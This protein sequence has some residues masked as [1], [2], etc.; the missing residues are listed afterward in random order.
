[1]YAASDAVNW[2]SRAAC[3]DCGW[4]QS[5]TAYVPW[6]AWPYNRLARKISP[7]FLWLQRN[8]DRMPA[9]LLDILRD[10]N[11]SGEFRPMWH[12]ILSACIRIRERAATV[13]LGFN[14]NDHAALV[15]S[16]GIRDDLK[17]LTRPWFAMADERYRIDKV[18]LDTVPPSPIPIRQ[19]IRQSIGAC[20]DEVLAIRGRIIYDTAEVL[21]EQL[22]TLRPDLRVY[23]DRQVAVVQT[24]RQYDAVIKSLQAD[25]DQ[26]ATIGFSH[27][28]QAAQDVINDAAYKLLDL[29]G[30]AP[31]PGMGELGEYAA[32][33]EPF[34]FL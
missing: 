24:A 29:V 22:K 14:P 11:M 20:R 34:D 9:N 8:I 27:Q 10:A 28:A 31:I 1:V 26:I 25:I 19:T 23:A 13:A 15:H 2:N 12:H 18:D 32:P 17:Q 7:D 5:D 16:Q 33:E 6:N 21:N 30:A 4:V 3:P